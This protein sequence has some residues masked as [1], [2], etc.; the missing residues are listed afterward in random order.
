MRVEG[1]GGGKVGGVEEV[2]GRG[3]GG[4][5]GWAGQRVGGMRWSRDAVGVEGWGC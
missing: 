3:V 2:D 1:V 4:G 5:G